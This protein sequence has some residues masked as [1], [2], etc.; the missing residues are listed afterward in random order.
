MNS[1][2]G[3]TFFLRSNEMP[4]CLLESAALCVFKEHT[5]GMEY[6]DRLYP[7]IN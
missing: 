3:S 2:V 1:F 5:S 7:T 4:R 6:D